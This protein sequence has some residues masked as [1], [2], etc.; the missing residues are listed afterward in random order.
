MHANQENKIEISL[1]AVFWFALVI[2]FFGFAFLNAV[3]AADL[4]SSSFALAPVS[5]VSLIQDKELVLTYAPEKLEPG[6]TEKEFSSIDDLV[7]IEKMASLGNLNF[8]IEICR[9]YPVLKQVCAVELIKNETCAETKFIEVLIYDCREFKSAVTL[10]KGDQIKILPDLS[11]AVYQKTLDCPSHRGCLRVW[12]ELFVAGEKIEGA[13]WWNISA[14]GLLLDTETNPINGVGCYDHDWRQSFNTSLDFTYFNVTT[15][16]AS[17]SNTGGATTISAKILNDTGIIGTSA[18]VVI[19]ASSFADVNFTF[20]AGVIL[21]ANSSYGAYNFTLNSTSS[22]IC[23]NGNYT[24]DSYKGG[25]FTSIT[26]AVS[27]WDSHLLL[28]GY[29]YPPPDTTAPIIDAC[30]PANG[31]EIETGITTFSI[32]ASDDVALDALNHTDTFIGTTAY[33]FTPFNGSVWSVSVD[34]YSPGTYYW[35]ASAND[36]SGNSANTENCSLIVSY[37]VTTTTIEEGNETT[38]TTCCQQTAPVTLNIPGLGWFI[39]FFIIAV[40]FI[41]LGGLSKS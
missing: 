6:V 12:E 24:L 37:P 34:L 15:A 7:R 14:Q 23:I 25:F 13:T 9:D 11:T 30:N 36:T 8:K 1:G 29:G 19:G 20:P 5:K 3:H 18:P 39:L 40:S 4:P 35:W 33:N 27:N 31:S 10:S 17:V 22:T 32:N 21:K 41:V 16:T 28:W 2:A 26:L 38:T